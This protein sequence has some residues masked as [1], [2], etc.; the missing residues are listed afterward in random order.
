MSLVLFCSSLFIVYVRIRD[1]IKSVISQQY[2]WRVYVHVADY[3]LGRKFVI[4]VE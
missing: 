1:F 2:K 4:S 3:H